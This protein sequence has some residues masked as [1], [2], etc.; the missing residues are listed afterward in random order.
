MFFLIV[1]LFLLLNSGIIY[2]Q[3]YD[4]SQSTEYQYDNTSYIYQ[5]F[6]NKTIPSTIDST[7][8]FY[9]F[10]GTNTIKTVGLNRYG[11]HA[12][13]IKLTA[14]PPKYLHFKLANEKISETYPDWLVFALLASLIFYI[15][16]EA[17]Q[18]GIVKRMFLAV[19]YQNSFNNFVDERN[20]NADKALI[21]L[22]A[23]YFLNVGVFVIIFLSRQK[24]NLNF[25]D[26]TLYIIAT[27]ATFFIFM[28]KWLITAM[29]ANLFKCDEIC[30]LYYKNVRYTMAVAGVVLIPLNAFSLYIDISFLH[31]F[32]FICTCIVGS[33]LLLLK[34][35]RL[36]KIIISK[37]FSIFY[38]FLYLC[39]VEFMP[40]LVGI[41]FATA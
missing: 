9:A 13:D 15:I 34:V 3:T 23:A 18:N 11:I 33:I 5:H 31:N 19:I 6:N 24:I 4:I 30:E 38:L 22:L 39:G 36:I 20:I 7:R 14:K 29:L 2:A 17:Y 37:H 28:I 26:N 41:R 1:I 32:V 25:S 10:N 12:K 16:A 8:Y 40:I 27:A 35:L 21:S